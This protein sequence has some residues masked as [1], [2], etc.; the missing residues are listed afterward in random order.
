MPPV[1]A[2]WFLDSSTSQPEAFR[3]PVTR[4]P[5]PGHSIGTTSPDITPSARTSASAVGARCV[6][7]ICR[8]RPWPDAQ[9]AVCGSITPL[10]KLGQTTDAQ[11]PSEQLRLLSFVGKA[12]HGSKL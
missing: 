12:Q 3:H 8:C 9:H 7:T 1:C 10:L 11:L 5:R 2:K 4:T 6:A